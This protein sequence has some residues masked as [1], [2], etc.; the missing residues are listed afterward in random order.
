MGA[1]QALLGVIVLLGV[2]WALSEN[3]RGVPW[4]TVAAGLGIQIVLAVSL[5][6]VP[7]L[8]DVFLTLNGVMGALT[9]SLHA[10]TSFVFGYLGG[11]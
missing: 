2:A 1:L 11:G 3:R 9:R 8:R 10:G 6:R 4:R 5:L 7:V